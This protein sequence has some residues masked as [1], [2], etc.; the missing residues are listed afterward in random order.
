ML[1]SIS[2]VSASETTIGI[3]DYIVEPNDT[4]TIPI[5][6]DDTLMLGGCEINFTYDPSVVHV[7]GVTPGDMRYSFMSNVN[8]PLE[9][10]VTRLCPMST[11]VP[12][13]CKQTR[14]TRWG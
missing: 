3:D 4:I 9:I 6:I 1:I 7:T 11:T 2:L 12:D 10:C 8:I 13:G 14:L 5:T